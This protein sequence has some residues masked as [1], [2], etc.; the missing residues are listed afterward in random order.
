MKTMFQLLLEKYQ[1][2]QLQIQESPLQYQESQ[3]QNQE[4]MN[5]VI[6]VI[7]QMGNT[8][9]SH[10]NNTT[11]NTLNFYLTH[12]CKDAES[13]HDFTERFVKRSV[14]FFKGNYIEEAHNQIDMAS[15][16]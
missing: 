8:T 13:I 4:L 7:P 15:N 9:N 11:N 14:D 3:L 12:T 10:N 16:I 5:K 1:E 6:D 2:S